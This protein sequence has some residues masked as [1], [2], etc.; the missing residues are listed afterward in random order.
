MAKKLIKKNGAQPTFKNYRGFPAALCVCLNNEVVH[1]PPSNRKIKGGD[2]VTL[3][4]GLQYQGYCS[5]MAVSLVIEPAS[6]QAKRLRRVTK[7]VLKLAVKKARAGNTTGD[8]GETIERYVTSQGFSPIKQL[9]GHGIGQKPHTKPDIPNFGD[10]LQGPKLQPGQT[11]CIEP[12]VAAGSGQV[13]QEGIAWVT[14]DNSL[15][16]HFEH[17]VLVTKSGG[18]ILTKV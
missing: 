18:E 4:L 14:Q 3:D 11:I 13:K 17:T 8:I 6:H 16:A 7:K 2:L 5:D 10:R 1:C 15:S 9:C 12:M